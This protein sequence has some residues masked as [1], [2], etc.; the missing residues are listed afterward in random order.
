MNKVNADAIFLNEEDSAEESDED[1]L[2]DE[3]LGDKGMVHMD[4]HGNHHSLGDV[5]SKEDKFIQEQLM[6]GSKQWRIQVADGEPTNYPYKHNLDSP[7]SN[8][9]LQWIHGQGKSNVR[10]ISLTDKEPPTM[11]AYTC[12]CVA[13]VYNIEERSQRFYQGHT[14]EI[15][16][17]AIHPNGH[18]IATGDTASN[19]H[20]WDALTRKLIRSIKVLGSF[21]VKLIC[22]SPNNGDRIASVSRDLDHTVSLHDCASGLIIGSGRG[23]SSPND[24]FDM[25]YSPSA[26][27]I[28]IVGRKKIK[29][30]RGL[31]A[32]KRD[33][34]ATEG[35]IGHKLKKRTYFCVSYVNNDAVLGCSDGSIYLF[36]GVQCVRAIQAHALNE[37]VLCM[38]SKEG[39]LVT[40]GKDGLIKSWD[41]TFKEIGA[42]LDMSEDRDGDGRPDSGSLNVAIQSVDVYD[43]NILVNT[44]VMIIRRIYIH[45]YCNISICHSRDYSLC[46]SCISAI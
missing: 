5:K 12:A 38:V 16:C 18:H 30:F 9:Q 3:D 4:K 36:Q 1:F 35:K 31:N 27:E 7:A 37:P 44:K 19:I 8:L 6:K 42:F 17:L 40:G 10:Y 32:A 26:D 43:N 39:I 29:F 33:L 24:V 14:N 2:E 11:I 21:G 28:V 45:V 34:G 15:L 13:I 23:F 41:S 22:F 46:S 20:V 25:A